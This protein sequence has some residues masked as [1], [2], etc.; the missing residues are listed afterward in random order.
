MLDSAVESIDNIWGRP[1]S[2]TADGAKFK[3]A[4]FLLYKAYPAQ[5]SDYYKKQMAVSN[6]YLY[7]IGSGKTSLI[8]AK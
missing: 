6:E 8:I 7:V 2:N 5:I 1:P 3:N 4:K